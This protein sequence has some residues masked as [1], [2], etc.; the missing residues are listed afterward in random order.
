MKNTHQIVTG[1]LVL[2]VI[3][4]GILHF[5]GNKGSGKS[6]GTNDTSLVQKGVIRIKYIRMDSL[7]SGYQLALDLTKKFEEDNAIREQK[8]QQ[9]QNYFSSQMKKYENEVMTL[10]QNE[11]ARREEELGALQQQIMAEGQEL[12]NLAQVQNQQMSIQLEDSLISFFQ[13]FAA[14]VNADLILSTN[15]LGSNILYINPSL[16]VTNQALK[17]LN[18]RYNKYKPKD[19]KGTKE[20]D[21]KDK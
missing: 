10:T 13:G 11:R 20:E 6:S 17:G 2:A 21:K 19:E 1:V 15:T 7:S 9:R 14:E 8:F 3:I 16:D 4:L 5:A 18:D 12:Q